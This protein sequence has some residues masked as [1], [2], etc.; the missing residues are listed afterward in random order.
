MEIYSHLKNKDHKE[1]KAVKEE[2]VD[3][4]V[5]EVMMMMTTYLTE[6]K[7][8]D[9]VKSNELI[10]KSFIKDKF[11]IFKDKNIKHCLLYI[12]HKKT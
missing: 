8:N 6:N 5:K 10:K 11:N 2:K 3:K 7:L 9:D 4:E 12:F 1:D